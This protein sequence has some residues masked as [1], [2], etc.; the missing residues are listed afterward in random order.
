MTV[1]PGTRSTA[2]WRAGALAAALA[3][4]CAPAFGEELPALEAAAAKVQ[5]ATCT[6]RIVPAEGTAGGKAAGPPRQVTVCSGVL[7]G[8]GLIVTSTRP[9]GAAHARVT[10]P[11]GEQAEAE[12]RVVDEYSGLVLLETSRRDLAKLV[13][14]SEVPK[15]GAWVLGAAGWGAEKPLLTLGI[16]AGVDRTLPGGTHP[17]LIQCDLRAAETSAGAP[18]VDRQGQLLG[19]V[20]AAEA[21]VGQRGATY[22]VPASH[23]ERLRHAVAPGKLVV[24]KRRRPLVGLVLA[25]GAEPGSVVVQ[26]VEKGG[27]AERAGLAV[28]D[29]IVA[30]EGVNIRSVYQA[31][32][33]VL[34]RQPGDTLKLLVGSPE[35]ARDVHVTLGGG[36]E[37]EG[38]LGGLEHV[39]GLV[40]PRI[41][42]E[43]VGSGRFDLRNAGGGVRNLAADSAPAAAPDSEDSTIR[44]LE[45]A[46]DRYGRLV[47]SLQEEVR[48]RD[49]ERAD[50]T[51]RIE[52]L[53][54]EIA[55]LKATIESSKKP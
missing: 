50:T 23:V 6:V 29:R 21:V 11:G 54:Q 48:R 40:Q 46:L 37:L 8:D 20:V 25:P 9:A 10:L 42:V 36:I 32:A 31:L 53:M 44:L 30:V 7:L 15:A 43:R 51:E 19:I 22:A 5:A 4:G 41:E 27:P 28:G 24:L 26:R 1:N 45:K 49:A 33:P 39:A 34:T 35:A 14:A 16:V 47:E 2:G 52:A 3:V 13:P 55:A 12:F 38:G 17:P 18:V